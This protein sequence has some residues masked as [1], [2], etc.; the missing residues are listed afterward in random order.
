MNHNAVL[1]GTILIYVSSKDTWYY[2]SYP[3]LL[4]NK[5]SLY[6][7]SRIVDLH[8]TLI[9]DTLIVDTMI[10]DMH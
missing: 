10:V 1:C 7:S 9:I 6:K 5:L 2:R 4:C 8:F 3:N